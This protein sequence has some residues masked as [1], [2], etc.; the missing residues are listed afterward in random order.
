MKETIL[1]GTGAILVEDGKQRILVISDLHLRDESDEVYSI[2]ED[3]IKLIK[4]YK[5]NL[6]IVLGDVYNFGA[7]GTNVELFDRKISKLVPVQIVLGNHDQEI[8]PYKIV[9]DNCCFTHGH[10]NFGETTKKHIFFGH[11]H[12]YLDEKRIFLKG[13]L[14]NGKKFTLLPV[15]NKNVG[16]PDIKDKDILLGYI[17]SEKLIKECFIYNLDGKK[18]GKFNI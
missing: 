1:K 14:K 7:G 17:F 18:I 16:G 11:T 13:V 15:F 2:I 6:L 3:T 8:F 12:A 9:S 4:K 10:I 5:A